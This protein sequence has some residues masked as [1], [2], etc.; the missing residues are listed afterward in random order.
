MAPNSAAEGDSEYDDHIT[1]PDCMCADED[2]NG[3][4]G[5]Y[6]T[7]ADPDLPDAG[8]RYV[9]GLEDAAECKDSFTDI[10]GTNYVSRWNKASGP[11]TMT[12]CTSDGEEYTYYEGTF[13]ESYVDPD[14]GDV[15]CEDGSTLEGSGSMP[16]FRVDN[17]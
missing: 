3:Q 10:Y 8:F 17:S 13:D 11:D 1:L 7:P 16:T 2:A 15:A 6:T 12:A 4:C 14:C 9:Y 5:V